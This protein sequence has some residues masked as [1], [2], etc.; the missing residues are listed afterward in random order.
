MVTQAQIQGL[1]QFAHCGFT[2]EYP[3]DHV[4]FL[5][6]EDERISIFSQYGATSVSLQEE[7]ARHL[8]ESHSGRKRKVEGKPQKREPS[9]FC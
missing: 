1:G 2:L 8:S 7:C 9:T 4:L 3:D 6:H 5:M